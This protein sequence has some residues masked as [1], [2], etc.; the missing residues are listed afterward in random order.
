MP[1]PRV[2]GTICPP[3]LFVD[4]AVRRTAME[5]YAEHGIELEEDFLRESLIR[6]RSY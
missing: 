4:S 3:P 5:G 6:S 2:T 1:F